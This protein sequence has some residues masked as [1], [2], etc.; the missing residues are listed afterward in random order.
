MAM[1][2][3]PSWAL[4]WN[5]Q[6]PPRSGP[7]VSPLQWLLVALAVSLVIA[8]GVLAERVSRLAAPVLVNW[9][10]TV[11]DKASDPPPLP[12]LPADPFGPP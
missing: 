6:P 8:V 10:I 11:V 2:G 7:R 9:Q 5:L 12:D 4:R 1:I 3:P